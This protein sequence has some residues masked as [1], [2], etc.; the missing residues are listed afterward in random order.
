MKTQLLLAGLLAI[1][2]LTPPGMVRGSTPTA[3]GCASTSVA[4]AAA[5]SSL[6]TPRWNVA[7]LADLDGLNNSGSFGSLGADRAGLVTTSGGRT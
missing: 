6:G 4:A 5:T 2:G 1:A 7:P 3:A